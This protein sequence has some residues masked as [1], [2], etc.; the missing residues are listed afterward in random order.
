MLPL[1]NELHE[2][3]VLAYVALELVSPGIPGNGYRAYQHAQPDCAK[4]TA[5]NQ[6]STLLAS[7]E[8]AARIEHL[9]VSSKGADHIVHVGAFIDNLLFEAIPIAKKAKDAATLVRLGELLDRGRFGGPRFVKETRSRKIET[10]FA[11]KSPDEIR[12]MKRL[13]ARELAKNDPELAKLL[14]EETLPSVEADGKPSEPDG[15]GDGDRTGKP[16][17]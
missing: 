4:K 1:Q 13:A 2:R 14:R 11:G 6:A 7:E 10:P 15:L 17:H 9:L 3:F 5:E 8:V 16:I 12:A